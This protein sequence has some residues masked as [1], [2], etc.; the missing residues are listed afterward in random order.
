M[1]HIQ[2]IT[3][4]EW[5]CVKSFARGFIAGIRDTNQ[6]FFKDFND[7]W[8]A[9]DN[10]IDLNFVSDEEG[11]VTCSAYPVTPTGYTDSSEF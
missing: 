10:T 2:N 6:Y 3:D 9:Y 5:D 1:S 11:N 4:S 7:Y 8:Y